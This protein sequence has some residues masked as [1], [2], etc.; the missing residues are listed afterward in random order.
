[1]VTPFA[2]PQP[3]AFVNLTA[4]DLDM[5]VEIPAGD[6][7]WPAD[8]RA[9]QVMRLNTIALSLSR[10]AAIDYGLIEPTEA[11]AAERARLSDELARR[12][13]EERAKPAPPLTLSTLLEALRW[14]PSYAEH[15]VHPACSC[16][17]WG[18]DPWLCMWARE[19]GFERVGGGEL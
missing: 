11:E 3:S 4:D 19:L 16:D 7:R 10:E 17:P 8:P 5:P 9:P 14:T 13:A 1:M 2:V 15:Y 6:P 18:E 12:V